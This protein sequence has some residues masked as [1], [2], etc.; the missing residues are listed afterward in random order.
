MQAIEGRRPSRDAP[1]RQAAPL[2]DSVAVTDR[3]C[4]FLHHGFAGLQ[5]VSERLHLI[6]VIGDD[7]SQI[8]NLRL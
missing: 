7:N 3:M 1:Y 5:A 2:R 4:Y 6:I 8:R